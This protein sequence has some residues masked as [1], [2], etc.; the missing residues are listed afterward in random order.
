M[1][2]Q[3]SGFSFQGP[4]GIR[5]RGRFLKNMLYRAGADAPG[6]TA[7]AHSL[8][9][10]IIDRLYEGLGNGRAMPG[11]TVRGGRR[12][13]ARTMLPDISPVGVGVLDD[14]AAQAFIR[15]K[16]RANTQNVCVFARPLRFFGHSAGRRRR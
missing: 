2:F 11:P 6:G 15:R 9:G 8:V 5:P 12:I 7:E 1:S 4:A 10:P 3:F 13:A 14:P 16:G